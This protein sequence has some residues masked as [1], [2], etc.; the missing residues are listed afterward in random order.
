VQYG[1]SVGE[2][3]ATVVKKCKYT[4]AMLSDPPAALSVSCGEYYFD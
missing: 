2:R 1:A 3:T 4:I